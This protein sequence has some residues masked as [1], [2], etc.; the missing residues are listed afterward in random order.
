MSKGFKIYKAIV[1]LML[2]ATF[3]IY[4]CGNSYSTSRSNNDSVKVD[5]TVI[6]SQIFEEKKEV[7]SD[8]VVNQVLEKALINAINTLSEVK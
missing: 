8:E 1:P 4:G 7:H 2:A 5:D 6:E 3:S